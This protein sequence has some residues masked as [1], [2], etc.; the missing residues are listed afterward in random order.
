MP[1]EGI[2]PFYAKYWGGTLAKVYKYLGVYLA[3]R[4]TLKEVLSAPDRW[5]YEDLA[6]TPVADEG[7]DELALYQVTS[8]GVAALARQRQNDA[9]RARVAEKAGTA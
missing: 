9:S 3:T 5:T 8:G 4:R 6:I 2:L 7:G 1:R